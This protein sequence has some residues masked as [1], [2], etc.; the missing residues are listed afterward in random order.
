MP[1]VAV[2][3]IL[4]ARPLI[5]CAANVTAKVTDGLGRPINKGV[6]N[7]YWLKSVSKYD[8]RKIDLV[9]LVSDRDG[10]VKGRYDETS[11]PKGEDICVEISKSGYSGYITTGLQSEFVLRREFSAA[12]IRRIARLHGAT[13][14]NELRE[15]LAGD[16]RASEQRPEELVFRR[17]DRFRPA[18][19]T[20]V[21]DPKVGIAAG[22]LLAFIGEPDDVRL[23]VDYAPKPKKELFKDRW[24]YSVVCALLEPS[25]E[26]EWTFVRNCAMND[27]DDRWVDAGAIKTLKLIASPRSKQILK[28]VGEKNTDRADAVEA[29]IEYIDSAPAP[30][31]DEDVVIAGN[32][33]AQAIRIGKW[34][35]NKPPQ[36]NDRKDKA[37]VACEFIAGRDLLIH[38]ATFHR[39]DGRWILR[40]VRETMQVLLARDPG[41]DTKSDRS[42]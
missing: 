35:G 6:V 2:L 27:Y 14:V 10:G 33:V 32:K 24:A 17:E 7:I 41:K 1:L 4:L 12:D 28:E 13:Q 38:T 23:F 39:V 37:L 9:R 36:F 30:L 25:T 34:Q 3:I 31:S 5:G 22:Q 42:N 26:K 40:G 8:V 16:F 11:I 15:F 20:L 29:A 21:E 19:R 18:L